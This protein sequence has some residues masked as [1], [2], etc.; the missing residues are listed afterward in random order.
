[1][2]RRWRAKALLC[3]ESVSGR[4]G[5]RMCDVQTHVFLKERENFP[6]FQPLRL[7]FFS[8]QTV[9]VVE[10]VTMETES[11]NMARHEEPLMHDNTAVSSILHIW[12]G[13][14]HFAYS[15]QHL[16]QR[17]FGSR[18][19]C[20]LNLLKTFT[21][22]ATIKLLCKLPSSLSGIGMMY[23]LTDF[24]WELLMSLN[25]LLLCCIFFYMKWV[26]R[27]PRKAPSA[28]SSQIWSFPRLLLKA[29]HLKRWSHVKCV[30]TWHDAG[31]GYIQTPPRVVRPTREAEEI[32][33]PTHCYSASK[34]TLA[35]QRFQHWRRNK[36]SAGSAAKFFTTRFI[37]H[38]QPF[39]PVVRTDKQC[40]RLDWNTCNW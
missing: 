38:Y 4:N 16:T 10:Y 27:F 14:H 40:S 22:A 15:E 21:T 7:L 26:M 32:A 6:S 8:P 9:P 37:Q 23:M 13:A 19:S 35:A 34:A 24:W 20:C 39:K 25:C 28:S 1:M 29:S 30:S 3:A 17:S 36:Q 33:V 5:R 12:L 31:D 18:T 2:C 11:L